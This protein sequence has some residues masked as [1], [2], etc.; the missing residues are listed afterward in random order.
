LIVGR[1]SGKGVYIYKKGSKGKDVNEEAIKIINQNK[2]EPR[3]NHQSEEDIQLRMVS[4][5]VNEAILCFEEGILNGPVSFI[6]L[7]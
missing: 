5:F 2:V 7:F 3:G 4:R 1:K 6:S